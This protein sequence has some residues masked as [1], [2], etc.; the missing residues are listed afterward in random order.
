MFF[1]FM[2]VYWE[3]TGDILDGTIYGNIMGICWEWLSRDAEDHR[4]PNQRFTG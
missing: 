2:G 3:C 4:R 1:F